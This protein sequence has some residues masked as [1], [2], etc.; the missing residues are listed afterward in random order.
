[1]LFEIREKIF[2]KCSCDDLKNLALT[3]SHHNQVLK[4]HLFQAINIGWNEML[5]TNVVA[6]IG[7][8]YLNYTRILHFED[9]KHLFKPYS[10]D[11]E[12]ELDRKISKNFREIVKNCSPREIVLRNFDLPDDVFETDEN[13]QGLKILRMV[14]C[15]GATNNFISVAALRRLEILSIESCAVDNDGLNAIAEMSWLRQL[16]LQ[17]SITSPN[18]QLS[19]LAG[20]KFLEKLDISYSQVRDNEI[21]NLHSL[22]L[23]RHLNV[24]SCVHLTDESFIYISNHIDSLRSLNANG[25][26]LITNTGVYHIA[27][28]GRLRSLNLLYDYR[29]TILGMKYI[30]THLAKSLRCLHVAGWG[31]LKE[32]WLPQR[33]LGYV[34]CMTMLEEFTLGPSCGNTVQDFRFLTSLKCLKKL[35]VRFL[36]DVTTEGLSYLQELP[37]LEELVLA[38]CVNSDEALSVIAEIKTLKQLDI[39]KDWH[40]EYNVS[41]AGLQHLQMLPKLEEL[42]LN[43]CLLDAD[44]MFHI[45]KIKTLRKLWIRGESQHGYHVAFTSGSDLDM[46]Q[47]LTQLEELDISGN[48]Q[49]ITDQNLERVC[50]LKGLRRLN[51]GWCKNLT[52]EGF[53]HLKTL[54]CLK[55]LGVSGPT[56]KCLL[57]LRNVRMVRS[58][59]FEDSV[60]ILEIRL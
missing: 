11:G 24:S 26:N 44:R 36:S 39:G 7:A 42:K 50:R 43:R 32:K 41:A 14:A 60:E 1:M 48:D 46:L 5:R 15:Q 28:T 30:K 22:P 9:K 6:D 19:F 58:N 25:C 40:E 3:N 12:E 53:Q 38:Q 10:N 13:L 55:V 59:N 31:G 21:L 23:L 27:K 29:I 52:D 51:L 57:T 54:P 18:P 34:G 16:D 35:D 2:A 20:L 4:P 56:N 17:K 49:H 33:Y 8:A 37:V 47:G 45:G